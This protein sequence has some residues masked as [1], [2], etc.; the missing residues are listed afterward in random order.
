M[1][2]P[3]KSRPFKVMT[4]RGP[5]SLVEALKNNPVLREEVRQVLTEAPGPKQKT[6]RR[7][8]AWEVIDPVIEFYL[9]N[10]G[11]LRMSEQT[12]VDR[13]HEWIEDKLDKAISKNKTLKPHIAAVRRRL[14]E[15]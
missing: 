12:F 3:G 11:K 5:V 10:A 9:F 1:A 14:D 13:L 2:D 4:S 6:G 8:F 15:E 7:P